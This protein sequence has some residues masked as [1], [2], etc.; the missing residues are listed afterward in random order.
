MTNIEI[1]IARHMLTILNRIGPAGLED[2]SLK[3]QAEIAA[4]QPL[5]TLELDLSFKTLNVR[6]WV[7]SFRDPVTDRVR[8][9]IT[10][11]GKIALASL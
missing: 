9:Y 11:S 3:E 10:E 2:A 4:R 8:W 6:G 1:L 7:A 5:T